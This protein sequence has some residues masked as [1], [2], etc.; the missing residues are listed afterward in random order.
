MLKIPFLRNIFLSTLL[1]LLGLA[2]YVFLV[3]FPDLQHLLVANTEEE[4]V[5]VSSHLAAETLGDSEQ[6][7]AEMLANHPELQ[8]KLDAISKELGIWKLR[9]LDANGK[10]IFSTT[11]NEVGK[12]N[13][14][15]YYREIVAQGRPWSKLEYKG[16]LSAEGEVLRLSI[17]ET[18]VP[19]MR[20]QQFA[21]AFETYYDISR[22]A[23]RM[24]ARVRSSISV[25]TL[26]I[27]GLAT[28]LIL[29]LWRAARAT[30]AQALASQTVARLG[31]QHSMMLNALAEGVYGVDGHECTTFINPAALSM[32]GLTEQSVVGQPLHALG[33]CPQSVTGEKTSD[34]PLRQTL[35]DGQLR[36]LS[37]DCFMR[38]DGRLFPVTRTIAPLLDENGHCIGAVVVFRDISAQ[39]H[40][41]EARQQAIEAAE[42]ASRAKSMFLANMSHEIRTPLNAVIGMGS[43][44]AQS[45]LD[46][47][48]RE[49][50]HTIRT[51]GESLLVL[52][53]DI[54][55]YSKIEAGHLEL[56]N[57]PFDLMECI[58]TSLEL[59]SL[60]AAE[61]GLELIHDVN[62]QLPGTLCGDIT[63]LRQILV[64][65]ITNAVKFTEHGQV[66][67]RAEVIEGQAGRGI[68]DARPVSL[69]FSIRDTGIGI[70]PEKADR[71]FKSFSQVDASTTRRFGGTGLGLAITKRLSEL[72]G[73]NITVESSGIAGEG[74]LFR[75]TVCLPAAQEG[76]NHWAIR[77]GTPL[78]G[79][80]L[81][82]VDDTPANLLVLQR[83]GEH[84]GM[85]VYAYADAKQA[86]S[87]IASGKSF[88]IA[89]VDMQM[90]EIDGCMLARQLAQ[91]PQLCN[92][93]RLMLSSL[94]H[95]LTEEERALFGAILSKPI[96]ANQLF[97]ALLRLT[98]PII[99]NLP[100]QPTAPP[101]PSFSDALRLLLVEDN[102][103]NQRVAGHLLGKLGM[104]SDLAG[105]GLEA[106]NAL[107]RQAYDVVLMD[108]QMPEMDGLEATR[109]IVDEWP[110]EQRP[111]IIAMTANAMEGDREICLAAGMNDYIAKPIRLDDLR[112]ALQRARQRLNKAG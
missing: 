88:D 54:L 59:V 45:N 77:Q 38:S 18:Y 108:V 81:L 61:K 31:K 27:I 100:P 52:I 86:F 56:E 7:S 51:S 89:V 107:R 62:P 43:L 8:Q 105:N 112:E 48:Q 16:G 5:R 71:L 20:N 1:G 39:R 93:P 41:D 85:Q 34:L 74:S 103:V 46:E 63:R 69:A 95:Q 98:Q 42:N 104:Q 6:I 110:T 101:L 92:Q 21:G 19:L 35:L 90:P 14:A 111:H 76:L 24:H 99:E 82:A 75:F 10:I 73:G 3:V 28:F 80:T 26:A 87:H 70:P 44:L 36:H 109:H 91:H 4:A 60:R 13:Q 84:W 50:V 83:L 72:M 79:K 57:H 53:N 2:L 32:L 94:G 25:T 17:V 49:Y 102:P 37:E 68:S 97:E 9:L 11:T 78:A 64:N 12:I 40:L 96:R 66:I 23:E 58:D 33:F 106:L 55:D 29:V 67:V 22:A 15:P 47:T 65:L 30:E